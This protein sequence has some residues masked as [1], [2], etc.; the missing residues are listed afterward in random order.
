MFRPRAFA[1]AGLAAVLAFAAGCDSGPTHESVTKDSLAAMEEMTTALKAVQD[2]ASAAAA[3]PKLQ[4]IGERMRKLKE[5]SD[6]LGKPSADADATIKK[7]YEPR[8]RKAMS[9]LLGET[10]RV[11]MDPKLGAALKDINIEAPK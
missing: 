1:V 10:M 2:E 4:A 6:K 3:K 5:Q 8:M 7:E 11:G 9:D